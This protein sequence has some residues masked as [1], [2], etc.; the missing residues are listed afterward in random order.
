MND[1][2]HDPL[3]AD[4]QQPENPA[5]V[6]GHNQPPEETP[7]VA[8]ADPLVAAALLRVAEATRW[9]TDHPDANK[10]TP[11]LA[12]EI[13]ASVGD[14]DKAHKNLDE[15]RLQEG[16]DFDA[17]QK[18][19]YHT[20]LSLLKAA[21]NKLVELRQAYL[22]RQEDILREQQRKAQEAADKAKAEAEEIA[23]KAQED[24]A[25]PLQAELDAQEAHDR[26]TALQ[27]AA[28]EAPVKAHIVGPMSSRATGLKDHWSASIHDITAAFRHYNSK[29]HPAKPILEAAIRVA[30]EAIADREAKAV[31]DIDK[32]PPGIKFHK[33]RR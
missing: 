3:A 28:E 32:A 13:N 23:R 26:A 20:P 11:A 7:P 1:I 33:D 27:Q 21:K 29:K 25:D 14:I 12:D 8:P 31:K 4:I 22:K 18:A 16:R 17:K 5:A 24:T 15:Q 2:N 6:R 19:K 30:I 9:L 10:W